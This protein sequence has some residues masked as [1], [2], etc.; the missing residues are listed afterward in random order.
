M[1]FDVKDVRPITSCFSI[2]L[3]L[4]FTIIIL[5]LH[6][7]L[8]LAIIHGYPIVEPLISIAPNKECLNIYNFLRQVNKILIEISQEVIF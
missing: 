1:T 3:L 2:V 6:R 5:F 8:H 4:L 7:P